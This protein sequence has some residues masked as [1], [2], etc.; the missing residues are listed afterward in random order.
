[1]GDRIKR[2]IVIL[3]TL[4][5][6]YIVG[7]VVSHFIFG[8]SIWLFVNIPFFLIS[9]FG[10]FVIMIFLIVGFFSLRRKRKRQI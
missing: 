9:F 5:A 6:L 10:V 8:F 1:M 4:F 7:E 3:S 2:I